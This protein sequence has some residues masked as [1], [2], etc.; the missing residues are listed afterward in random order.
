MDIRTELFIDGAWIKPNT[1]ELMDVINPATEECIGR[2]PLAGRAE[3]NSAVAAARRAFPAWSVRPLAERLELL[4][5]LY[6][7]FARERED[8]S[9]R[10]TAEMGAP[11]TFARQFMTD[12]TLKA[13][14]RTIEIARDYPLETQKEGT[15]F[16]REAFGVIGVITPWNNPA[17]MSAIKVFPAL[18]AGC[19]VVHKPA[20][21]T[22]F[23]AYF[24]AEMIDKVGFPNGVYNLV[25]GTGRVVGEALDGHADLDLLSFTGS[26]TAGRRIAELASHGPT[27]AIMELGGKSASII[28][29][30]A[31]LEGAIQESIP[32][33]FMNA[34]QLCGSW[35]RWLVPRA[36]LAKAADLAATLANAFQL[37]DPLDT[38][39]EMGPLVSAK[40]Y[41]TVTDY[42]RTGLSEGAKLVAG[43]TERPAHLAK[44]YYVSPTI[45]SQVTNN[46]RIAREEIFGPVLCLLPYDDDEEAIAIANDSPYGLHGG[47]F[48]GDKERGLKVARRIRTGQVHL[49]GFKFDIDVPF[50]G[51]RQ[52]GYGRCLGPIGYEEYLQKKAIRL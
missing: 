38:E 52:S 17:F 36:K 40:Q 26:T 48:A 5:S 39:T 28:L 43:G 13:I 50:G 8:L 16:I 49:N 18:A 11:I 7:L 12:L 42:I 29:D 33:V 46:M 45:F 3:V 30:D 32:R 14:A 47:V 2:F 4:Q 1:A 15:F 31:D 51:Y 22:P 44:G 24:L 37:G 23:D 41:Q 34:G 25:T 20:E 9:Q 10:T 19:A 27:P 35:T 21:Y 6:D